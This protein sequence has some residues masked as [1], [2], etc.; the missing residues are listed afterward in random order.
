MWIKRLFPLFILIVAFSLIYVFDLTSFVS[1]SKLKIYYDKLMDYVH[2]HFILTSIA[3]ILAYTIYAALALPGIFILS[4]LAGGLFAQ[5]LSTLYVTFAATC[6]AV[7][8][9][10]AAHTALRGFWQTTSSIQLNKVKTHIDRNV[11]G[12][13]LFMRLVP[14]FPFAFVNLAAAFAHVPFRTFLWTTF[15]GILPGAFV[16][17]QAGVGL[18][19]FLEKDHPPTLDMIFTPPVLIGFT[20]VL[21]LFLIPFILKAFRKI[22]HDMDPTDSM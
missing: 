13:L 9:F 17:T 5:P 14:L 20:G 8:L 11:V 2:T 12:Y 15:I 19:M 22:P 18:M 10:C 16:F 4:L 7:I 6:G 1:W 21:I 3:F